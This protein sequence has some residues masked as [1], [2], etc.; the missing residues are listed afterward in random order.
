MRRLLLLALLIS[1]VT[2][3][4]TKRDLRDL[5]D[6]VGDLREAQTAL[7]QEIQ[8]Q[9]ASILDTLSAQD[10]RLRGDLVNQLVEIERQLA[11]I[12]EL[13][14]QGQQR[15]AEL[16]EMRETLRA[17]QEAL[18]R[19]E[20]ASAT[21][22]GDPQELFD[23][24]MDARQRGSLTTARAAFEEFVSAF[25]EHPLVADAHLAIGDINAE[26]GEREA[27]LRS[28]GRVL[29]LYPDSPQAPTALLR[30]A[31]VEEDRGNDDRASSL[32]NQLI[33]AYPDS[34][35]AERARQR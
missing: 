12:H 22:V 6:E 20:G 11:Q 31:Q 34:P 32:R 27:A 19:A 15:L 17:R 25:P 23:A 9:N 4:A 30:A 24:A 1:F 7:L 18:D 21:S 33:A 2:G 28:Y 8:R 3:C 16:S 10:L 14:G 13:T 26:V 5:R 35:E 29:E